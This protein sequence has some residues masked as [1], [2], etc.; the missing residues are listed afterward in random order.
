M[1][2]LPLRR[3]LSRRV[4]PPRTGHQPLG[5]H[6]VE[7]GDIT[8]E[9]LVKA[10]H[11]QRTLS[12]PLGEILVA[13]GAISPA[14]LL[15][16]LQRQTG[17]NRVD[18]E[19]SPAAPD[20]CLR[21][22]PEFC[23]HHRVIPWLRMG[24][25]VA[26]ATSRPDRF[27]ALRPALAAIF[28]PVI[29]VLGTE[30]EIEAEIAR[31]YRAPLAHKA[32][33]RVAARFS[34][35]G[36]GPVVQMIPAGLLVLTAL[37]IWI[38]PVAALTA[39]S[40]LALFC[41][42]LF[43]TLKLA[44]VAAQL[45]TGDPPLPERQDGGALGGPPRP[46]VS[47]LVP[48]YRESRIAET[49]VRRLTRLT[50]PKALLDVVLVLEEGDAVTRSALRAAR[51]PH[52]MRIVEVPDHSGLRTKPRAM[53]YALDFCRGSIIGIWDAE[54]APAYDQIERVAEHFARASPDVACVQGVLDYYNPR[55]NWIAR[56]FT[57]EYSAWFR[58]ILPG[59]ARLGLVVPLGGTTLFMRRDRLEALGG[60][61]AHNVTED[62]DLGVRLCRAG[63]RTEMLSSVTYEE[64]NCRPWAWIKQRSRWLKGFLVTY[65][66]HMRAPLQL[67]RDL[68]PLRFLGMQ[69]FFLGTL[70]QFILAPVLWSFWLF[71]LGLGH[72]LQASASGQVILGAS[73]AMLLAELCSMSIAMVAV[74]RARRGFLIAWVP[75]LLFY[76]PLG[77]LAAIKAVAE[78]IFA[79]YFWDKTEHG[80]AQ[81]DAKHGGHRPP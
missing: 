81:V 75:T 49:L 48:L 23:L 62:A 58:V 57:I 26:F 7:S 63:Y 44:A 80:V 16:A 71:L 53:N 33:T 27:E 29:V 24:E 40:V 61:D 12:A 65:I 79:P 35:R 13:D 30:A 25:V 74:I 37:A 1:A 17:L 47:V 39:L 78:L 72:P 28:G 38:T 43:L 76:F 32:D 5:R 36:I 52:W 55:T 50:Y 20:L 67:W 77:A 21:L 46:R 73:G 14:M 9:Q 22:T 41:L 11:L 56:C 45:L 15:A 42:S 8:P 31:A 2:T 4:P 68:G 60:W 34:C 64:A 19:T 54:D 18:F 10:L 66:V 6:L 3:D 59:I 51:L 70:S 69:A